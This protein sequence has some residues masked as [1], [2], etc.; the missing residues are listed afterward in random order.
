M[1]G[2]PI[3]D[4]HGRVIGVISH[5]TDAREAGDV[6]GYGAS[7]GAIIELKL[8]LEDDNGDVFEFAIPQLAD[9]GF[10]GSGSDARITLR[11]DDDGVT[12]TWKLGDTV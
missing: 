12:L 8:D 9:M 10:L 2:G 1:S 11:R 7:I 3:I 5:G 4:I 6:T